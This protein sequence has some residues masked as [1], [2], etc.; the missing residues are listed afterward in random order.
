MSAS[1]FFILDV[2]KS[3]VVS[4]A[5]LDAFLVAR[6][7]ARFSIFLRRS[8]FFR[9]LNINSSIALLTGKMRFFPD[10]VTMLSH[11]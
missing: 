9:V 7:S 11:Q 10:G 4:F 8:H 2:Y 6:A 3:M 1:S 5:A